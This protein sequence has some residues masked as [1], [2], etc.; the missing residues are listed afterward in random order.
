LKNRLS[1]FGILL[2]FPEAIPPQYVL[3]SLPTLIALLLTGNFSINKLAIQR[4][5]NSSIAHFIR[6]K[7]QLDIITE[8]EG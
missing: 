8:K 6:N 1:S 4:L 2:Q 3:L 5:V 7:R